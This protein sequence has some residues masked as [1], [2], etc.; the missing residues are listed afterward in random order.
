MKSQSR[1][2]TLQHRVHECRSCNISGFSFNSLPHNRL[3]SGLVEFLCQS[4]SCVVLTHSL[5]PPIAVASLLWGIPRRQFL[6]ISYHFHSGRHFLVCTI[7][8]YNAHRHSATWRPFTRTRGPTRS[9][10][11]WPAGASLAWLQSRRLPLVLGQ[12]GSEARVC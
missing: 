5:S 4:S 7:W 11:W 3:R 10:L 2:V 6:H 8:Q 12:A 9:T 1:G